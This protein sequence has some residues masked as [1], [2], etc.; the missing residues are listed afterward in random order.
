MMARNKLESEYKSK[1]V[2]EVKAAGGW[3]RRIE[4]QF[5]VGILDTILLLPNI[6]VIFAEFKRF[7]GNFFKPRDRQWVEMT[8]INNA[9]G[10]SALI[11]VKIGTD[12]PYY[13]HHEAK[14]AYV[15]NCVVQQDDESFCD[16]LRRW[17][18]EQGK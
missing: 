3:A 1:I 16:A 13:F 5:G 2:K 9:G 6:P 10:V 7:D 4:D 12:G 8:Q 15:E 18:K 14:V 17:Y 11:G